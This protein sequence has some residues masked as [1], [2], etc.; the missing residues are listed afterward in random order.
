MTRKNDGMDGAFGPV[1]DFILAVIQWPLVILVAAFM[2]LLRAAEW[3]F[4]PRMIYATIGS[5][6]ILSLTVIWAVSEAN[7]M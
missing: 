3:A 5:L 4:Q 1:A 6:L 7:G 2:G